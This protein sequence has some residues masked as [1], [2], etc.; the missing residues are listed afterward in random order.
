MGIAQ[1]CKQEKWLQAGNGAANR[2]KLLAASN[3]G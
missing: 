3:I 1:C 2:E